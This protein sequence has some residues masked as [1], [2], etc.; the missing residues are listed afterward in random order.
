MRPVL[1]RYLLA[2]AGAHLLLVTL[3][4]AKV[5]H[6][7]SIGAVLDDY[8]V[9]SGAENGYGFFAPDVSGLL[10]LYVDLIDARGQ[11]TTI[12]LGTGSTHE[13]ALRLAGVA[14][15]F[16]RTEPQQRRE[17]ATS[18]AAK[19]FVEHPEAHQIIIRVEDFD[20]I[21]MEQF[22]DGQRAQS[23]PFYQARF[24]SR[25]SSSGGS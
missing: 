19:M 1:R 22:K 12:S 13:V 21:S 16:N 10:V 4:A 23:L 8:G 2:L 3:G 18:L 24:K 20:S 6:I 14:I 9:A 17:L 15:E 5:R 25:T 7:G 11:Q